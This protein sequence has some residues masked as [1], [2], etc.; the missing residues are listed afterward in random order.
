MKNGK[1]SVRVSFLESP[2]LELEENFG[3]Y[4][5]PYFH[6]GNKR[7]GPGGGSDISSLSHRTWPSIQISGHTEP[8]YLFTCVFICL[9]WVY[10]PLEGNP[11]DKHH[12]D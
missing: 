3:Y 7:T 2:T 9:V 4:E 1:H 8:F 5:S 10:L 12:W 6:L 11:K